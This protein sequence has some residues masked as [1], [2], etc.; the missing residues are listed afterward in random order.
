MINTDLFFTFIKIKYDY[1][2]LLVCKYWY[3]NIIKFIKK[4]KETFYDM[5]LYNAINNKYIYVLYNDYDNIILRAHDNIITNILNEINKD[6]DIKNSIMN[7]IIDN[8]KKL[9]IIIS[10]LNNNISGTSDTL[11]TM[12]TFCF[13]IMEKNMADE[14]ARILSKFYNYNIILV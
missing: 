11:S 10:L 14:Y 9:S 8:Y 12:S 4:K 3:K 1:T 6:I 13:G 2:N 7:N 5:Q